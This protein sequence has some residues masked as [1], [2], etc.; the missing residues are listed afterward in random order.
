MALLDQFKPT[1]AEVAAYIKNRTVD[2]NNE[3]LGDFTED[4]I[5]TADEV[6]VIIEQAG[7]MVLSALRWEVGPPAT[8]PDSNYAAV[9]SLVALFS[10]IFVEVTKF[11]EQ[12]ARQ[13]SPYPYLKSLFD[14]MLSQKQA[15][16]GI[17]P[18]TTGGGSGS[19]SL[20]DLIAGQY[21][22]AVYAFPDNE[23]V[24]WDTLL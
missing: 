5:V 11:S 20:V 23:M 18:P 14:G 17:I 4:T 24:N 2:E 9:K 3:Y 6:G 22:R 10:A 1:T 19:L 12:I 7:S 16:L 15:D 13:V 8:I 21:G